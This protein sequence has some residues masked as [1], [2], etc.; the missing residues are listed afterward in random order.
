[1]L[2]QFYFFYS[3]RK[4][5]LGYTGHLVMPSKIVADEGVGMNLPDY[6][7][8]AFLGHSMGFF[9]GRKIN[10][11]YNLIIRRYSKASDCRILI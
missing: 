8:K 2:P 3:L 7:F 10:R 5:S 11:L 6:D 1:M 4:F 9:T